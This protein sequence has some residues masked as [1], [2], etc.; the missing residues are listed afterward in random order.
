MGGHS[1]TKVIKVLLGLLV[2]S[3]KAGHHQRSKHNVLPLAGLLVLGELLLVAMLDGKL[4]LLGG[5]LH[6]AGLQG[7]DDGHVKCCITPLDPKPAITALM[8]GLTF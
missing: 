3:P 7:G 8:R 4:C 6:Q 2:P 5:P 1:A